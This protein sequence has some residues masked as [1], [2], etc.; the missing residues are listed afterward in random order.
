MR[1]K[2]GKCQ[3]LRHQPHRS[4]ETRDY[5]RLIAKND[6]YSTTGNVSKGISSIYLK[7]QKVHGSDDAGIILVYALTMFYDDHHDLIA[8]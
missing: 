4:R 1:S 6:I 8:I 3:V 2:V 5:T 7:L